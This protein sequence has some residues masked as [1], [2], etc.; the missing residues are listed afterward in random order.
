[1]NIKINC[2]VTQTLVKMFDLLFI[3]ECV[4]RF[5][6]FWGSA[7]S[8]IGCESTICSHKYTVEIGDADEI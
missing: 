2:L 5:F 4:E 1:M 8:W 7:F 6:E 3:K